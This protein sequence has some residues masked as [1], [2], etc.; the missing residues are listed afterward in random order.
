MP[1]RSNLVCSDYELVKV[2]IIKLKQILLNNDYPLS[3]IDDEIYKFINN[4]YKIMENLTH[5]QQEDLKTI[6]LVNV[7][8]CKKVFQNICDHMLFII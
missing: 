1:F 7:S 5:K 2:E 3:I 6:E 8:H 4:K